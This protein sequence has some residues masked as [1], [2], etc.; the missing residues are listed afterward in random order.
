MAKVRP[1]ATADQ[2]V[3]VNDQQAPSPAASTSSREETRDTRERLKKTSIAG[4][5]Q[6]S[7]AHD[8]LPNDLSRSDA[9]ITDT[10]AEVSNGVRGRPAKKRSFEDL[11]KD[12]ADAEGATAIGQ[13]PLPKSG[14]HK[15]MRS[16]DV[17]SGDQTQAY[18]KIGGDT[19]DTLHEETDVDPDSTPG[20]PGV[21]VDAPSQ[22]EMEADATH[23]PQSQAT[24]AAEDTNT[25]TSD[26]TTRI[27]PTS[28]FANT[29]T[30]SAF[31][32]AKSPEKAKSPEPTTATSTSAFPS[33]G[34][35]AFAS[36]DKS[37][38]GAAAGAK[39]PLG[40]GGGFSGPSTGGFGSTKTGFGG[41]GGFGATSTSTFGASSGAFG[42]PKPFGGTSAF[43][44]PKPFGATSS[45]GGGSSTFGS[46]KPF[47]SGTKEADDEDEG[48]NDADEDAASTTK[49]DA[50]QDPRFREQQ[51]KSC[52]SLHLKHVLT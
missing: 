9:S 39:S 4:L 10:T 35:S 21:L 19:N 17:N 2:S 3:E 33:S 37:P 25:T 49:D 8:A 13:P 30:T 16:R 45:F 6:K 47:T 15:R 26:S 43:G 18:A 23:K 44:A 34:L 14:H 27:P 5:S 51:S 48:D 50:E 41:S 36:S 24:K 12:D 32:S 20:G 40:T 46:A 38:F 7:H 11:A 28:G 22:E 1:D 52:T 29:S 42:A 31:A